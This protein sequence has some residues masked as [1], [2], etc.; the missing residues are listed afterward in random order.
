[1]RVRSNSSMEH[2][3]RFFDQYLTAECSMLRLQLSSSFSNA[4]LGGLA[5]FSFLW[6][7]SSVVWAA[8]I[9]W[10]CFFHTGGEA[11]TMSRGIIGNLLGILAGWTAGLILTQNPAVIPGP[12]WG[13]V[14]VGLVTFVMVFIGHQLAVY[15]KLTIAV[16]PAAF[17]GAAATFAYMVQTP[18]KLTPDNLLSASFGN[19]LVCLPIAMVIG[20]FLG[21]ATAKMTGA[22]AAGGASEA[23]PGK[24]TA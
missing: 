17:Y 20:S 9:A 21:L 16:V 24:A 7:G 1:M 10:G 5:V 13:G 22:L 18:G 19:P 6:L 4:F 12:V 11:R 14:M 3:S 23:E 2:V 8:V 15:F